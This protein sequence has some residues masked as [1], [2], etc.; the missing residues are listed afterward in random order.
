M[1]VRRRR[2]H[3]AV[4]ILAWADPAGYLRAGAAALRDPV[5]YHNRARLAADVE[6]GSFAL[7]GKDDC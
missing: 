2:L 5:L 6:P 7:V 4:G 3:G 1:T